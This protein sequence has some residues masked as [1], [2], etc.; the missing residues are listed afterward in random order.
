M[1][2]DKKAFVLIGLVEP[3]H[4]EQAEA[5]LKANNIPFDYLENYTVKASMVYLEYIVNRSIVCYRDIWNNKFVYAGNA[6]Y[7]REKFVE[8]YSIRKYAAAHGLNRG[9]VDYIQKKFFTALAEKLKN[10]REIEFCE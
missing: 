7:F 1:L 8:G 4:R 9:S 2:S 10:C 5:L 6:G 3:K